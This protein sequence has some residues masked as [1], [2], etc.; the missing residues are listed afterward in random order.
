MFSCHISC[1]YILFF[2]FFFFCQGHTS[3]I[4]AVNFMGS[5]TTPLLDLMEFICLLRPP[6]GCT[7][8]L[9]RLWSRCAWQQS[10]PR[11]WSSGNTASQSSK[12][13]LL[14][15]LNEINIPRAREGENASSRPCLS[16]RFYF[17]ETTY[18]YSVLRG[19][20]DQGSAAAAEEDVDRG[21][22]AVE[23]ESDEVSAL[24]L[25]DCSLHSDIAHLL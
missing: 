10:L 3:W 1:P 24:W 18:R 25:P 2:F 22:G 13:D 20:E 15:C 12:H 7:L 19:M 5:L 9:L 11:Y 23:I 4:W 17:S 21:A 16:P 6:L 8:G 14:A